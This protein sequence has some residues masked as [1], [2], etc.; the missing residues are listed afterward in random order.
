MIKILSGNKKYF[1]QIS[2]VCTGV[3]A[4]MDATLLFP[5]LLLIATYDLTMSTTLAYYEYIYE[6]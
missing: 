4:Y 6:P 1:P 3:C 5:I 2:A